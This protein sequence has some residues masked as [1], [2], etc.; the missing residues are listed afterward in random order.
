MYFYNMEA[1]MTPQLLFFDIDGTL[2]SWETKTIPD[3]TIRAIRA[4]QAQGHLAFVNTARTW[5]S[6]QD[7]V[8][9][10]PFD[11]FVCGCST[12]VTYHGEKIS[13]GGFSLPLSTRIMECM[14]KH[15]IEAFLEGSDDIYC[16]R[17]PLRVQ[18]MHDLRRYYNGMGLCLRRF[19]D[20]GPVTFDKFI[21]MTDDLP[22]SDALLAELEDIL[23][24]INLGHGVYECPPK[25]Y[26]KSLGLSILSD[27]LN[28]P[29]Q[30][31]WAFG[32]SINDLE[33][34]SAAGHGIAM[35]LHAEALES[36]ADDIADT[37]E[38]DGILKMLIRGGLVP[39]D[40]I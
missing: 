3:S 9:A 6:V 5:A 10:I 34:L 23:E 13:T 24:I 40:T 19:I 14:K 15:N 4:A 28:I 17:A 35:G 18:A 21:Y 8:K 16:Q 33:M 30:D 20:D 37:V 25:G 36:V 38:N 31:T 1:F 32:D 12:C 29:M 2:V 27:H 26:T 11:G 22:A 7:I 39:E